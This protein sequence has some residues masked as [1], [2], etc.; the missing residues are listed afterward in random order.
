[1]YNIYII[2][3]LTLIT[4]NWKHDSDKHR[5]ILCVCNYTVNFIKTQNRITIDKAASPTVLACHFG[6]K[7]KEEV[8]KHRKVGGR[9]L[10]PLVRTGYDLCYCNQVLLGSQSP[11]AYRI[12]ISLDI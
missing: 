6:T 9:V 11:N 1:M 3:P 8:K 12:T 7:R 2:S 5:Y 4:Y 10:L